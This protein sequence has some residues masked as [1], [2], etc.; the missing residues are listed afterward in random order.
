MCATHAAPPGPVAR[1]TAVSPPTEGVARETRPHAGRRSRN[2][3]AYLLLAPIW[4]YGKLISPLFG[5]RCR[6]YPTCSAYAEQAVRELGPLRGG[7]VAAWRLIRC[8]P[9]SDGGFDELAD[10]RLFRDRD[11]T[12]RSAVR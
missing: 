10:R 11:H 6:Y 1:E 8:N 7:I 3:L 12:G 5:P 4:L 2:P 9:L